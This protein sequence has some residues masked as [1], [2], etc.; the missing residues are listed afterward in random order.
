LYDHLERILPDDEESLNRIKNGHRRGI[1]ENPGGYWME[2]LD[3][4]GNRFYFEQP[5]VANDSL[6]GE[7]PEFDAKK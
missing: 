1:Y 7:L 6:A 4:S 3:I 5:F 2:F